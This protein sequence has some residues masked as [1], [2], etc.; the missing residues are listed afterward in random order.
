[1]LTDVIDVKVL[2]SLLGYYNLKDKLDIIDIYVLHKMLNFIDL[3]LQ[4][5]H[6][7]PLTY[8]TYLDQLLMVVCL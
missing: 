5:C 2:L 7:N 1:M 4:I 3:V 8:S 6:P